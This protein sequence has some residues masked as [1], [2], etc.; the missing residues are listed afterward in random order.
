MKS[1]TDLA[2]LA[3]F[4][5]S[6]DCQS[7]VILTGAGVSVAS[8]IPDFR[9]PAGMFDTLRPELIT[10]TERQRKLM[11]LDPT[12]VV[13][14]GMFLENSFP[15]LEVRR[16]FILGVRD[17]KWKPTIAHHFASLLHKKTNK[18]T[19]VFTQNIDGLTYAVNLPEDKIV[20]VHG[21]IGK[22]GCETCGQDM[23]FKNF[24]A[25]VETKIK[26]IYSPDLGPKESNHILCQCCGNATVK[27]KTVLFGSSLPTEFFDKAAQDLPTTDLLIVAGTSLVVSPANSLV[28]NIPSD[29]LR[30][31][32]NNE[33]VGQELG[34]EYGTNTKRDFF[35][36]GDCDKVFMDLIDELGWLTDLN[37]ETNNLP[38]ASVQLIKA[39]LRR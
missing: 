11:A 23:D 19:R 39:K 33:P 31:V 2:T 1:V 17:K 27:P 28:N 12:Y 30:V 36:R 18:L 15:Y 20:S 35:A 4:I 10:A 9:S 34:I 24:C 22:A 25:E 37:G 8:G 6:S 5:L 29:T 13:E 14:R 16:P 38:E 7:I 3:R 32:I 21:T 26:D